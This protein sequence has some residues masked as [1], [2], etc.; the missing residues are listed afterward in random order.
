MNFKKILSLVL[1]LSMVLALGLILASCG[2]NTECTEHTDANTDGKCDTC[3]AEVEIP[4][5]DDKTAY[6]VTL[7]DAN[8]QPVAGATLTLATRGFT[9]E[10][11][12]TDAEG[13][14][15]ASL[16]VIGYV[17]ASV[18]SVPE[19]YVLPTAAV[20][21]DEGKTEL[22]ISVALDTRIAHTIT[23]VDSE[24]NA[25]SDVYVQICEGETCHTPVKTD[26][27]GKA[28]IRFDPTGKELKAKVTVLPAGYT[29]PADADSEGYIHVAAGTTEITLTLIAQ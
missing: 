12:T 11:L 5:G 10:T 4:G 25:I 8:N 7:K 20:E 15:T 24:G 21:F 3:G 9:S 6:T 1:A 27:N 14:A 26:A 17:K 16:K 23:L 18:I 2:G 22:T 19:G 28:V 29:Y 13:K